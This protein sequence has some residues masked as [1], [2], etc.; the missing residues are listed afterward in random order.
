MRTL[1]I[2]PLILMPLVFAPK[3]VH[4]SNL[5]C[6]LINIGCETLTLNELIERD[7]RYFTKLNSAPF[8]GEVKGNSQGT[9]K[10]GYKNGLWIVHHQNGQVASRTYWKNGNPDGPH[11]YFYPNGQLELRGFWKNTALHGIEESFFE[12]GHLWTRREYENGE[13]TGFWIAF[14]SNGQLLSKGVHKNGLPDGI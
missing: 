10:D 12:N 4:A 6:K 11:E 3:Q 14:H 1:F 13:R 9:I 8:S 7:G 2:I 5:V